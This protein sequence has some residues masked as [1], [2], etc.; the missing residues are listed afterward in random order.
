MVAG[1][2][3]ATALITAG[4]TVFEVI[5]I[6]GAVNLLMWPATRPLRQPRPA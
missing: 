3:I 1:A 5:A 6:T 2:L 4:L